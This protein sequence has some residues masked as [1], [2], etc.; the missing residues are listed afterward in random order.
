MCEQL[1]LWTPVD[2]LTLHY[3]GRQLRMNFIFTVAQWDKFFV[4]L[5]FYSVFLVWK[6][7]CLWWGVPLAIQRKCLSNPVTVM[8]RST[9]VEFPTLFCLDDHIDKNEDWFRKVLLFRKSKKCSRFFMDWSDT[10][11]AQIPCDDQA[12]HLTKGHCISCCFHVFSSLK[13]ESWLQQSLFLSV[14]MLPSSRDSIFFSY[15]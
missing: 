2:N 15:F 5:L 14:G 12:S 9:S 7:L 13:H 10:I 8:K 3:S 11:L 6:L 1:L 4:F